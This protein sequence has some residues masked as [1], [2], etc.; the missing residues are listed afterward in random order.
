MSERLAPPAQLCRAAETSLAVSS[1]AL[2]V[3]IVIFFQ[4]AQFQESVDGPQFALVS[5]ACVDS[6]IGGAQRRLLSA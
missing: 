1:D 6:A 3:R 5:Q 4:R 2:A